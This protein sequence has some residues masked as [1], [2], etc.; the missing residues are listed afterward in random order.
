MNIK[1]LKYD[2][3]IHCA[4]MDFFNNSPE[5][6]SSSSFDMRMYIMDKFEAY[7]KWFSDLDE[8]RWESIKKTL[9]ENW[10]PSLVMS[11]A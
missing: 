2:F 10:S 7:Y 5:D 1:K 11:A 4:V 3:S 9:N 8:T 6:I